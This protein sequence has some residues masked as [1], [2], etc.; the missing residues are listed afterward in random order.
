MTPL[1]LSWVCDHCEKAPPQPAGGDA[2]PVNPDGYTTGFKGLDAITGT[3]G[4]PI[5]AITELFGDEATL[6]QCWDKLPLPF[7]LGLD[8]DVASEIALS[9]VRHSLAICP[10]SGVRV[11]G[12]DG[13]R[14]AS[15]ASALHECVTQTN[16]GI[17]LFNPCVRTNPL[18]SIA[19]RV[20]KV[21][22]ALRIRLQ[23]GIA[24]VVKNRFGDTGLWCSL[25][26]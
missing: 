7:L 14:Y 25:E 2:L 1:F 20:V 15:L 21:V 18:F 26:S 17:V 19:P 5:G 11:S 10:I 16:T 4:Y 23:G 22:A 13:A 6:K 24:T 3:G 9:W 12:G 8:L